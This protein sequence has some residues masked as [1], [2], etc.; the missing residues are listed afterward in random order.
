MTA[1]GSTGARML[2]EIEETTLEEV[3]FAP[4]LELFV[5]F[6]VFP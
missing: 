2:G 5:V 1:T 4:L 6:L 3:R